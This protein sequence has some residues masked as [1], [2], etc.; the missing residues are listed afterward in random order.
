M[1]G[2]PYPNMFSVELKEKMEYLNANMV[3][4][5]T[6]NHYLIMIMIRLSNYDKESSKRFLIF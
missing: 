4:A 6:M 1:V 2:L 3:K 5:P